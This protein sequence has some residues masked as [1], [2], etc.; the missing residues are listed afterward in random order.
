M[1][2]MVFHGFK[3]HASHSFH[4]FMGNTF[5]NF[6]VPC[7]HG[8]ITMKSKEFCSGF[9]LNGFQGKFSPCFPWFSWISHA[10]STREGQTEMLKQIEVKVSVLQEIWYASTNRIKKRWLHCK[11]IPI[12]RIYFIVSA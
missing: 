8:N 5:K 11:K 10:F 6:L 7:L 9:M 4:A 12:C 2:S 3:F 1:F